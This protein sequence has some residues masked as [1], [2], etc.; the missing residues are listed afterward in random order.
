GSEYGACG[1]AS[2][3]QLFRA[4]SD[5]N[6][7]PVLDGGSTAETNWQPMIDEQLIQAPPLN[8]RSN[9]GVVG[10]TTDTGQAGQ[11]AAAALD[12]TDGGWL[13]NPDTGEIWAVGFD[14]DYT[15]SSAAWGF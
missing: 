1:A 9:S 13:Y 15:D 12:A 6:E 7:F 3:I 11:D 14:E 5:T 8:P 2:Q 10:T 4:Q